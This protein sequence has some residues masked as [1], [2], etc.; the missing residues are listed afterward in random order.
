MGFSFS[1]PSKG[2]ESNESP[3][4]AFPK[5]K[6]FLLAVFKAVREHSFLLVEMVRMGLIVA[7]P[8]LARVRR[9]T[10]RVAKAERPH[11]NHHQREGVSIIY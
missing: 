1:V 5:G 6:E 11:P 4:P 3:I 7:L 9:E 2:R 8:L 10:Y